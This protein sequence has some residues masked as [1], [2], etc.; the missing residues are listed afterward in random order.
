[1]VA[2]VSLRRDGFGAAGG[3]GWRMISLSAIP[4]AKMGAGWLPERESWPQAD[5]GMGRTA[6]PHGKGVPARGKCWARVRD[7]LAGVQTW[8]GH[9]TVT[10]RRSRDSVRSCWR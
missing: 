9:P 4:D 3:V 7:G 6:I 5:T 1:M 2:G 10:G 8:R